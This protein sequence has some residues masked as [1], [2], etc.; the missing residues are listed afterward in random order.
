MIAVGQ[1]YGDRCLKNW[2]SCAIE[3]LS[4][5]YSSTIIPQGSHKLLKRY[6]RAKKLDSPDSKKVVRQG[7]L[8]LLF[9]KDLLA[10]STPA[11]SRTPDLP[12]KG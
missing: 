8:Y 11:E 7:L 9:I 12:Y 6:I 2:A 4:S 3:F 5:L 10:T 1:G